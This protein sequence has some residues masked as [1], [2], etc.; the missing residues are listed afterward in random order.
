MPE[1][2]SV[3]SPVIPVPMKAV[4][5]LLVKVREVSVV[6]L[7]MFSDVRAVKPSSSN[8]VSVLELRLSVVRAESPVH[9]KE[10]KV[11]ELRL[12]D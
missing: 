9:T 7:L 5:V 4:R 11:F 8:D 1:R 6:L 10:V 3:R 2:S 12:S